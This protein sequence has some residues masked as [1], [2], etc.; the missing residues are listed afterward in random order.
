MDHKVVIKMITNH[1]YFVDQN[2][3][4]YRAQRLRE[5]FL[6]GVCVEF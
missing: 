4:I 1:A 3:Q 2:I 5:D 6:T